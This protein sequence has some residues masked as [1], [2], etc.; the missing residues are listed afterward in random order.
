MAKPFEMRLRNSVSVSKSWPDGEATSTLISLRGSYAQRWLKKGF[1]HVDD[2]GYALVD[3]HCVRL[4]DVRASSEDELSAKLAPVFSELLV[5]DYATTIR[6]EGSFEELKLSESGHVVTAL[7]VLVTFPPG[8]DSRRQVGFSVAE[9]KVNHPDSSFREIVQAPMLNR[10]VEIATP[11]VEYEVVAITPCEPELDPQPLVLRARGGDFSELVFWDFP[12]VD[13]GPI[14]LFISTTELDAGEPG[15]LDYERFT[16]L[17]GLSKVSHDI[18]VTW[19]GTT[20]VEPVGHQDVLAA[21]I[22]RVIYMPTA[23]S[24][25]EATAQ[26]IA[27]ND[28]RVFVFYQNHALIPP[29]PS[30]YSPEEIQWWRKVLVSNWEG[31][32]YI[33]LAVK[34]RLREISPQFDAFVRLCRTPNQ[35]QKKFAVQ[36]LRECLEMFESLDDD[37]WG[38]H[39][40]HSLAFE[41]LWDGC[42]R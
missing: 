37:P 7:S 2:D 26:F 30:Y 19:S 6:V 22:G 36:T 42:M 14:H 25:V 20:Y 18:A 38:N 16:V 11:R 3:E 35:A 8:P 29:N 21:D 28:L 40:L 15:Q 33:S 24:E 31:Y 4:P 23:D 9:K 1:F 17:S 12:F 13:L 27:E 10:K 39:E 34:E 5:A 32:D 41:R